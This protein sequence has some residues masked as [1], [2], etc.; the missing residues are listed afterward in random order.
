MKIKSLELENFRAF[1]GKHR[2][3]FSCSN[4]KN[5]TIIVAEN[6]VGKS[7]LLNALVWCFYGELTH[8]TDRPQDLIHDDAENRSL[9]VEV[10]VE[11]DGE[12]F[13]FR[14]FLDKKDTKLKAWKAE[15]GD[16]QRYHLPES[17]I[18]TLLPKQLRNYFLFSGEELKDIIEEPQKLEKSIH[19]IQGLTAANE[20]LKR[21]KQYRFNLTTQKRSTTSK[22]T[23]L[24]NQKKLLEGMSSLISDAEKKEEE[25]KKKYEEAKALT[26]LAEKAWDELKG[27][28]AKTIRGEQKRQE[29][30]VDGLKET[31]KGLK[32]AR[33][34]L[35]PKF[36]I[37]ILGYAFADKTSQLIKAAGDEGYPA[38]YHKKI[39]N[40]SLADDECKLCE[41]SFKNDKK[42]RDLLED[43]L[44]TSI[45]GELQ[46]RIAKVS[47]SIDR[48]TEAIDE[49]N[50]EIS[51][52][53]GKIDKKIPDL[54]IQEKLLKEIETKIDELAGRDKEA[55]NANINY[56]SAL[57]N[58]SICEQNI[59]RAKGHLSDLKGD[60]NQLAKDIKNLELSK[61]ANSKLGKEISFLEEC[62]NDLEK[63]IESQENQ[64]KEFIFHDMN[65]SL[66]IHSM[67]NHEF[68][69]QED[70]YNP[71]IIK[72]DGKVLKLST[73]GKILKK[74]LFFVTSLI[75]HSKMRRSAKS[76]LQIPG[77]VAP[78]IVDAPFS[79][80]D[81][82]NI[83]I[84]ARVLLESSEQ[85]VVMINSG[86][87][88]GG[89][90]DVLKENNK[91][92]LK[93][94]E[95]VYVLKR[96]ERGSGQGKDQKEVDIFGKKFPTA[97]YNKKY[98]ES[99]I[100]DLHYGE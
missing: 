68:R 26:K 59:N 23:E 18:N 9:Y 32:D 82:F 4:D 43:K 75:K 38:T 6:E 89:F 31:I 74:N 12:E 16:N 61:D 62:E 17:L 45:T 70:T 41:R 20:A 34:D 57:K 79:T 84:A 42:I 94:L 28:D 2:I 53:E 27:F 63:L 69:F 65:E 96:N 72:S 46:N 76:K 3:D 80:L 77:T 25:A 93:G 56:K 24:T 30:L 86:S 100:E 58:E 83:S 44:E 5:F 40:D 14:R 47:A 55:A 22:V 1:R 36:G 98:D 50:S 35:I 66:K 51:L 15:D 78:L 13:I 48:N 99:I 73:G 11:E 64:G 85:L 37:D 97:N 95:K 81:P 33:R 10:T 88:N 52:I 39:I 92:H 87:F 8:D 49:F 21:L 29:A 60:Q 19:D 91:K 7:T 67:G 90:L 54:E 71:E